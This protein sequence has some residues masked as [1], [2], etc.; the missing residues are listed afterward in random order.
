METDNEE[1][2][3]R[4]HSRREVLGATGGLMAVATVGSFQQVSNSID[5]TMIVPAAD[6]FEDNYAGQFVAINDEQ[7]DAEIE[8]SA[9]NDCSPEWSPDETKVYD[10]QLVDRRSEQPIAVQV[11]V[12]TNGNLPGIASGTMFTINSATPCGQTYVSLDAVSV[13]SRSLVG[14]PPGPTVTQDQTPG[15][16]ALL[17]G[18]GIAG[19]LFV[20]RL[21]NREQG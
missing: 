12:F 19:G 14:K 11:P 3:D 8:A 7:I 15:F 9:L 5:R 17:A 18:G 2:T 6:Q 21:W 13:R 1:D 4:T 10:G 20:R 16:G